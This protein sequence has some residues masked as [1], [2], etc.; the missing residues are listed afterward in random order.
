MQ[1]K[2]HIFQL[3]DGPFESIS[4]RTKTIEMRLFDEKRQQIKEGDQIQ[5]LKRTDH[6][7]SVLTRVKKLHRFDSFETLYKHFDKVMLGYKLDE[8]AMPEDMAQYYAKEEIEN[9]GVVGIEIEV[10]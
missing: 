1:T 10:I 8:I 6:S 7:V 9:Y 5:F 4:N 2:T 3:N